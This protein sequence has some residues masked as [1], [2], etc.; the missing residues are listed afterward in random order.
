MW[1][2][3]ACVHDHSRTQRLDLN[4]NLPSKDECGWTKEDVDWFI[5]CQ[6]N[7]IYGRLCTHAY[8][9]VGRSTVAPTAGRSGWNAAVPRFCPRA[10]RL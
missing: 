5:I 2:V 6:V 4:F 7:G 9:F 3:R 1:D 8:F 10:L